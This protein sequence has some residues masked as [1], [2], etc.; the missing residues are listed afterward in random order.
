MT[1]KSTTKKLKHTQRIQSNLH[2]AWQLIETELERSNISRTTRSKLLSACGDL[3][4]ILTH[5][6][7]QDDLQNGSY[8]CDYESNFAIVKSLRK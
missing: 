4:I 6:Q 3:E 1:Q 7:A 5:L 8:W 2:F